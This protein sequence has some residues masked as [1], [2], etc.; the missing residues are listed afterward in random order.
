MNRAI[1]RFKKFLSERLYAFQLSFYR[2]AG[3]GRTLAHALANPDGRWWLDP[4]HAPGVRERLGAFVALLA[5]QFDP[6]RLHDFRRRVLTLDGEVVRAWIRTLQ[7]QIRARQTNGARTVGALA[8]PT[9][10]RSKLAAGW[11][12]RELGT[13]APSALGAGDEGVVFVAEG[14]VHKCFDTRR[15]SPE[16]ACWLVERSKVWSAARGLSSLRSTVHPSGRVVL[17]YRF[18]A[19]RPYEGGHGDGLR[20]LLDALCRAGVVH[21]NLHPDNLRVADDGAVVLVDYGSDLAP[22]SGEEIA[23]M[24]RRAFLCGRYARHPELKVML[25]AAVEGGDM[26]ELAGLDA[27]VNGPIDATKETLL[28]RRLE[29]MVRQ[30]GARRVFDYG[31]G[32]GEV[33]TA[34]ARDGVDVVGFDPDPSLAARWRRASAARF[35]S[36]REGLACRAYDAVLCALVLCVIE[37]DEDFEGVVSDLAG[38]VAPGGEVIVAVCNPDSVNRSTLLQRRDGCCDPTRTA[39]TSKTLRGPRPCPPP[40]GPCG[41][42]RIARSSRCSSTRHCLVRA[43]AP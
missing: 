4:H 33:A 18:E 19:T 17:S 12:E 10:A 2:A 35:S 29:R 34:L 38:L 9:E 24:M 14:A 3:I 16:R 30:R 13:R 43:C 27:F 5:D 11:L 7:S 21:R 25:R 36:V 26:P 1:E 20:R 15:L 31:C 42:P 6:R 28:D 37:P 41:R 32:K 39:V 8:W 22:A 23:C 40:T